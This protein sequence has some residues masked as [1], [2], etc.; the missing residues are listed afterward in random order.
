[1]LR[2]AGLILLLL[3]I[4]LGIAAVGSYVDDSRKRDKELNLSVAIFSP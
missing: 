4:V 1:M 3:A 2:A